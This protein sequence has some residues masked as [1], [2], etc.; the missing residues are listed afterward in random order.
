MAALSVIALLLPATA[1]AYLAS[2]YRFTNDVNTMYYATSVWPW[3]HALDA[4]R[5][6]W[7]TAGSRYRM[8]WGAAPQNNYAYGANMGVYYGIIAQAGWWPS[9]P[10]DGRLRFNTYYLWSLSGESGKF[11]VQNTATHE[12]GHW[13][14]LLDLYSPADSDKTMYGYIDPGE[15]KKRI[16]HWDDIVGIRA[17][18]GT[19]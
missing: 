3:R 1:S 15:T 14:G 13:G 16:L 7:N 8:W 9:Y 18:Y 10:T 11:D 12:M 4:A 19:P 5:S 6:T 2:G 17:V